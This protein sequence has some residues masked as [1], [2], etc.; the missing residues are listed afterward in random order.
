MGSHVG[1]SYGCSAECM[2]MTQNLGRKGKALRIRRKN[3][4]H[5]S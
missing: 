2:S 1:N 4:M 3:S 5:G